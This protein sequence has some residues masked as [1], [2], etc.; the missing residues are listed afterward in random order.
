MTRLSMRMDPTADLLNRA[1]RDHCCQMNLVP[2]DSTDSSIL[3]KSTRL[4]TWKDLTVDLLNKICRDHG[5][6]MYLI[7]K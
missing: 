5:C 3:V 4:P 6:Q 1:Y 2:K 7:P